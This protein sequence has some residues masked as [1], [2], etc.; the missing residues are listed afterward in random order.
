L[1]SV[2]GSEMTSRPTVGDVRLAIEGRADS[3]YL[4]RVAP[5]LFGHRVAHLPLLPLVEG[6]PPWH[7]VCQLVSVHD[8]DTM[9]ARVTSEVHNMGFMIQIP[10]SL[11]EKN[12]RLYGVDTPEIRR[13]RGATTNEVLWG[14]FVTLW[15]REQF[16][17]FPF[18]GL[19]THR[20]KNDNYSRLLGT[21][22]TV[23]GGISCWADLF[24][25]ESLNQR[26]LNKGYAMPT[27]SRGRRVAHPVHGDRAVM[28]KRP[29]G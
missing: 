1:S 11:A 15:V 2:N 3:E 25:G 7:Y 16:L 22:Y 5:F 20:D 8:G 6:L 26:L 9:R 10:G 19:V 13:V 18:F 23:Q 27:D 4:D 17:Q 14:K 29:L 24:K 12:I 21:V 28:W